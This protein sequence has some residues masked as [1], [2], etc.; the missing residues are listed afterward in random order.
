LDG[1][2]QSPRIGPPL[3]P[4]WDMTW[5]HLVARTLQTGACTGCA[6][7]VIACPREVLSLDEG[8]W[9]P[10]L[11]EA[12]RLGGD[13]ARCLYAERGCTMCA[14]ACPRL[15]AWEQDGDRAV[16]G[17][18]RAAV[19][20]LGIYRRI[21]LVSATDPAM[22]AAGQDGGLATAL[23]VYALEHDL[24]DAA[25]VS[26]AD[27]GMRPRPGV[28]RTRPEVLAA[29]GSRYTYSPNTLAAASAFRLGADRLG[30]VSVGCQA[31]VPAV[32]CARGARRLARGF[33]LTIGLLCSRTF[34]DGVFGGLLEPRFGIGRAQVT[35]MNIKGRLQVWAGRGGGAGPDVEVP[36]KE[37]DPFERPGCRRCPDF[38]AEHA[39]LSLGGIGRHAGTT[40]TIV[41]S[42]G[43]ADL[44]EAMERDGWITVRDAEVEDPDAVALI[45]RMAAR[46][47]RRWAALAGEDAAIDPAPGMLADA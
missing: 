36:L 32:A 27:P 14:R 24:I 25:V 15:G 34:T 16:R 20:V 26:F 46:Q 33:A 42:D 21:S 40:L 5:S 41:R 11:A 31:S 12:A 29:A 1:T 37:C 17:R 45:A 38:T 6:G 4:R 8:S 22:A 35:R 3:G 7:C 43:G 13:P 19:E 2:E 9:V 39:D 44:L 23:L 30:L 18:A 47:R 10:R 28:A